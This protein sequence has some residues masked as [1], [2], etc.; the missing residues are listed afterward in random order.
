M[1]WL[2]ELPVVFY[3]FTK[4]LFLICDSLTILTFVIYTASVY[5][6]LGFETALVIAIFFLVRGAGH[7]WALRQCDVSCQG[8]RFLPVLGGYIQTA[9]GFERR[10]DEGFSAIG[11]SIWV[12]ASSLLAFSVYL[13]T[14][15]LTCLLFSIMAFGINLVAL[16]PIASSFD[17]GIVLK[18]ITFSLSRLLGLALMFVNIFA[19]PA[20]VYWLLSQRGPVNIV[21]L[22]PILIDGV[23][24]F[25]EEYRVISPMIP[26]SKLQLKKLSGSYLLIF[27]AF[28]FMP[29]I[30]GISAISS[31]MQTEAISAINIGLISLLYM[32]TLESNVIFFVNLKRRIFGNA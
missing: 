8:L 13:M 30:F 5:K 10:W 11:A 25:F 32:S 7:F 15:N 1:R 12:L 28:M 29:K 3:Q 6:L 26:M 16:F 9:S 22:V 27:L 17:G 14:G 20:I 23:Q 18:S 2:K 19:M 24:K 21:G 31:L 4:D